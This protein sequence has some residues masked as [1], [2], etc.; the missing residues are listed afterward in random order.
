MR[1]D[2]TVAG[3]GT[4]ERVLGDP[5]NALVWIANHQSRAG[6]GLRAGEIISTGTCT[7]L[8]PVKPGQRASADFGDLGAVEVEFS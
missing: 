8:A 3:E 5:L 4:G 7:G 6:R 1:V 2:G